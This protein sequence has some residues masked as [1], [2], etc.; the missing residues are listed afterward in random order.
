MCGNIDIFFS[1]S[2]SLIINLLMNQSLL[3]LGL[4]PSASLVVPRQTS[5]GTSQTTA[6]SNSTTGLAGTGQSST[7]TGQTSSSSQRV[8]ARG[9]GS[10]GQV[11]GRGERENV[12]EEMDIERVN[13]EI[14]PSTSDDR[15]NENRLNVQMQEDES[16]S[17]S[18]DDEMELE[19]DDDNMQPPPYM[20]MPQ[21]KY[22]TPNW[23][24]YCP[25]QRRQFGGPRPPHHR[26]PRAQFPGF[27]P[28][29]GEE[30]FG[31]EG[32]KLGGKEVAVLGDIQLTSHEG[33]QKVTFCNQDTIGPDYSVLNSEVSSF[34]RL[35]S[36]QM[37]HLRQTSTPMHTYTC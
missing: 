16:H 34:Q 22:Q 28:L 1:S 30:I 23:S 11:L 20:D 13:P 2:H 18:D 17:H 27:P 25:P 5:S 33:G 31:G 29:G 36:I 37:C 35:L 10:G 21:T 24:K 26:P 6:H 7:A 3:D 32:H 4:C 19:S 9:S 14:Q 12:E 8:L 15:V